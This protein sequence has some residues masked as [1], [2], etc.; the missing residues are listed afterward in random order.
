VVVVSGAVAMVDGY[1]EDNTVRTV[2][3]EGRFLGELGILRGQ[4]TLLTAVAAR[5]A[6]VVIVPAD[7]LGQALDADR[8]LR[9][10]VLRTYLLRRSIMLGLA[11]SLR[12]VGSGHS[13]D[14][15]RL[16]DYAMRNDIVHSFIDLDAD[17]RA[18]EL[19][20][21]LGIEPE[22]TPV[23]VTRARQ[24]LRNPSD[25]ELGRALGLNA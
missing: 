3:G 13:P 24:V 16:R 12:I 25:D 20:E 6:D 17:E 19:L 10:L 23:A 4:A 1:G 22:E 15:Q 21:Q 11:S 2:H 5:E 9:D 7:R 18:A 14:T 8:P